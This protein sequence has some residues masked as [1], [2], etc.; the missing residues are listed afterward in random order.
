[1]FK[2]DKTGKETVLYSFAGG[3]D[4]ENPV[5]GL[6]WDA[7]GN[8]YGITSLGGAS[9]Y[10]TVFKLDKAGK[11]TVL[12]SFTGPA[13]D[14]AE[15]MAG[16]TRDAKGNLYGTTV[17]GG[18]GTCKN[19]GLDGC[20]TVFKLDKTSKETVLYSFPGTE[21]D[22][23]YPD[24]GL[25]PDAAGNLYD[26][27]FGGGASGAGTVFK[28]DKTG[29]ETVLYSFDGADGANPVAGLVWDAKGNL[30]GTT[31]NGASGYGTVFKLEK[32][33]KETVLHS[34]VG[35]DGAHPYAGLVRDA[36]GKLYG[37]TYLGGSSDRGTVW[38]LTP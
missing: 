34:F 6:V 5:A 4:G 12:H 23:T 36:K 11:E 28:L 21:S 35:T 31:Y 33:G 10:G 17:Y 7:K 2:L 29:K 30:Y 3:S 26:T 27:T 8:L 38:K 25:V 32:T 24:A 19:G 1:M 20:G 9:G 14:G 37:T 13:G 15:P 16:L 18:S 22:G